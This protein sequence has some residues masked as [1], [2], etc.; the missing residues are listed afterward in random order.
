MFLLA[1]FDVAHARIS[2]PIEA[3]I[4]PRPLFCRGTT[5]APLSKQTHQ[6][7]FTPISKSAFFKA[8][9]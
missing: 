5:I 4:Q 7:I 3:G 1:T 6:K 2:R 9:I 8:E